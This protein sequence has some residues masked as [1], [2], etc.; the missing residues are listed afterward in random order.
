MMTVIYPWTWVQAQ[1]LPELE[2][3]LCQELFIY[4]LGGTAVIHKNAWCLLRC[5]CMWTWVILVHDLCINIRAQDAIITS[6]GGCG[7]ALEHTIKSP[8]KE[9][10]SKIVWVQILDLLPCSCVTLGKIIN[11]SV[12]ILM[13]KMKILILAYFQGICQNETRTYMVPNEQHAHS[14]RC[15]CYACPP[16]ER[17]LE[18]SLDVWKGNCQRE[19]KG[20]HIPG[21][22]NSALKDS[23]RCKHKVKRGWLTGEWEWCWNRWEIAHHEPNT[24]RG[25]Q[26][27]P[28]C[29]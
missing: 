6:Q 25:G 23:G 12:N 4:L 27:I 14:M 2:H 21:T 7:K 11:F 3:C 13:G 15:Y 19:E 26:G 1:E 10:K 16:G 24:W 28:F 29:R 8:W 5:S 18:L 22:E 17:K 20:T 9:I